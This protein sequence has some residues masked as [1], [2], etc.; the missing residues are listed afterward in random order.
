MNI[1][2]IAKT[3]YNNLEIYKDQTILIENGVI[4]QLDQKEIPTNYKIIKADIVSLGLL[5]LQIYGAGKTLFS[6]DLS[7]ESLEEMESA[8]INQ[9][10]TG[11]LATLATNSDEV[12]L[13][14]IAV[15]KS[16]QPKIGNF[17]GLHLEGP[18]INPLK[19][20]AHIEKYIK[21]ATKQYV[22]EIIQKSEGIVK[23]ITIAP[24]LQSEEIIDVLNAAGI[25]ISA[26]HSM[27][28][29]SEAQSFFNKIPATTHLF[30]AMPQ[31]QHRNPGLVAAIFDKMP[32]ASIVADGVHVDFE[33]IKLAKKLLRDRL[34]LI[35]DA[36]TACKIGPYQH[37]FDGDRYVMPD[38]TLSGSALTMLKAV[39]NCVTHVDI[40][41]DEALRMANSYPSKL[42]REE[43]LG[44]IKVGG[45]ANLLLLD[46]NLNPINILFRDTIY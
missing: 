26:G 25:I 37:L 17:L 31:L 12:F 32:Y 6:A 9:G 13:K 4:T 45:S 3:I 21:V 44:N 33:M 29:F 19:K 36:V 16:Y 8:L 28:T 22:A 39:Q 41:I 14:A 23:M 30:N 43:K 35:T 11:F 7:H 5:D 2:I 38:G 46:E 40:P 10:C 15:A 42:L 20:G 24:E 18:F 34:F 27:A 1:A